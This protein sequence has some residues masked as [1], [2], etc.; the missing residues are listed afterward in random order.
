MWNQVK[1]FDPAKGGSTP[2]YCLRNVR[3]GYGIWPL[4]SNAITAWEHTEQHTTPIPQGV[5]VPL[6]FSYREDGHIGVNLANG[7]FWSDGKTY[8]T[9]SAYLDNHEPKYLGWGESINKQRVLEL[10]EV[11]MPT[12]TT[13]ED[14]RILRF[15]IVG[16]D[17][18]D[19]RPNAL[20]GDRDESIKKYDVGKPL[21]DTINKYYTSKL[22]KNY[23]EV[24]IPGV[25]KERDELRQT[26]GE[27]EKVTEELWRKKNG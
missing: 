21:E 3:Q 1:A 19:G 11:N 25:Y 5:D 26:A 22:A 8:D 16:E 23:R 15:S 18:L 4:Y 9:L 6:F 13:L 12:L 14:G 24:K 27:F 2:G 10:V 20:R 7:K 17:G